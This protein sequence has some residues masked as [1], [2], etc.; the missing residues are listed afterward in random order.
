METRQQTNAIITTSANP[1]HYGHLDIFNKAIKIFDNVHIVAAYNSDKVPSDNLRRHLVPYELPID[2]LNPDTCVADYC[3]GDRITHIVRGIRNGVDAEYELK[4][5]FVN[6]EI[7]PYVQTVF[8][9]TSDTYS[10][11]SSSVLRELIRCGKYDVV[12]RYM[13]VDAMF[14]WANNEPIIDCYYGKSCTGKSS[15]L[16]DTEQHVLDVDTYFWYVAEQVYGKDQTDKLRQTSRD[17]V[18]SKTLIP[19]DKKRKIQELDSQ[20][21]T[22]HFWHVFFVNEFPK[23][24][25]VILDW[26]S[27]GAYWG[28]IPHKFR[29]RLNLIRVG[30]PQYL[31]QQRIEA[32]GFEDKISSIDSI[33]IEPPFRDRNIVLTESETHTEN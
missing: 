13:N 27:V 18:Y 29:A 20:F 10:N 19:P 1:F 12:S 24:D 5:D 33:Y 7:Y 21:C 8:I 23:S 28:F 9:P 16:K 32:K 3:I 6:R 2:V 11:I 14:R 17:I 30:C 26:A 15:Y 31:R 22:S 25:N 4:V